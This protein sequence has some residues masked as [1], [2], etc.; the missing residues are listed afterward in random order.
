M[1]RVKAVARA[2]AVLRHARPREPQVADSV[3]QWL[4]T[5]AVRAL[6]GNGIATLGDLTIA[7]HAVAS[8]GKP[9]PG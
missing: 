2:T 3:K 6:H 9:F 5:S 4:Q 7:F 8:G 1:C